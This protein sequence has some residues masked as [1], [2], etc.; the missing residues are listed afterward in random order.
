MRGVKNKNVFNEERLG[1]RNHP[2]S[3]SARGRSATCYVPDNA[4]SQPYIHRI[5]CEC[6]LGHNQLG[7]LGECPRLSSSGF[8][9]LITSIPKKTAHSCSTHKLQYHYWFNGYISYFL[10][11]KSQ[12]STTIIVQNRYLARLLGRKIA[13]A[14]SL[15]DQLHAWDMSGYLSV[16]ETLDL[17]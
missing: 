12:A 16:E 17:L 1:I 4:G 8:I 10:E 7:I 14:A 3:C 13:G 11:W 9:Q 5:D 15:A 6:I 2:F